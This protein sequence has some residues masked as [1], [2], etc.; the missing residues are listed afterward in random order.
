M[1][2]RQLQ[3]PVPRHRSLRHFLSHVVWTR[4]VSAFFDGE[5]PFSFS[6]GDLM[7]DW[8]FGLAKRVGLGKRDIAIKEYGAGLGVLARGVVQRLTDFTVETEWTYCISEYSDQTVMTHRTVFSTPN[9]SVRF[10]VEDIIRSEPEFGSYDVIILNYLLDSLPTAHLSHSPNGLRE[11]FIESRIDTRDPIIDSVHY[12]P[13]YVDPSELD[14]WIRTLSLVEAAFVAPIISK[15]IIEKP[16]IKPVTSLDKDELAW[17]NEYCSSSDEAPQ[18]F[19]FPLGLFRILDRLW[20][21]ISPDGVIWIFDVAGVA[22]DSCDMMTVGFRGVVCYPLATGLIE[23][24]WQK[25]GGVVSKSSVRP[26]LPVGM[27]LSKK[28][29]VTDSEINGMCDPRLV[30][31]GDDLEISLNLVT[32][33][34][35]T[36]REK[37][38]AIEKSVPK[39]I[40]TDYHVCMHL[41]L[42]W[43][44][45]GHYGQALDW[46]SPV[47]KRYKTVAISAQ[48]LAARCFKMLGN[49]TEAKHRLL[50]VLL[51][52]P[53]C[54]HAYKELSL[55]ALKEKDWDRFLNLS[56]QSVQHGNQDLPWNVILTIGLLK[57]QARNY[58]EARS[59]LIHLG[60]QIRRHPQLFQPEFNDRVKAAMGLLENPS[61]ITL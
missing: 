47:F 13:A 44:Q 59:L 19:N 28:E 20:D 45:L 50:D 11:Y 31:F 53:D 27:T 35:P 4:G 54:S 21:E 52:A 22:S 55:I 32:P 18:V 49:M 12:P 1:N 3:P 16:V 9:D 17:L 10:A 8:I 14:E 7:V 29:I 15:K 25:R 37:M 41:A 34:D 36:Y 60:T 23:W 46:L 30:D 51:V 24:Y 6:N 57:I 56:I 58:D 61:Q 39:E 26:G 5:V 43:S 2:S 40:A 38:A 48:T 42:K 33:Q